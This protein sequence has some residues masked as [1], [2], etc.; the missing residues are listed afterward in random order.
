MN[1]TKVLEKNHPFAA[2]IAA[3]SLVVAVLYLAGFAYRWSYY[4]NFGVQHLVF[5]LNFQSFLITSM[6]LI[7]QPAN[8]L[9]S[10]LSL[11]TSLLFVNFVLYLATYPTRKDHRGPLHKMATAGIRLLG[12]ESPLVVDSIRALVIFYVVYMLSSD[13]GYATFQQHVINSPG[14]PLPAVTAIVGKNGKENGFVLACGERSD[15]QPDLIGNAERVRIIKKA[16]RTC[17]DE[18][19]KWRL[20][21]RDD[22]AIYLFASQAAEHIKGRRPLTIVLPNANDVLLL[23]E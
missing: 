2:L 10:A 22:Q 1:S 16:Y 17:N 23:M 7:R 20:L 15:V 3:S 5:N 14:N 21:Y 12:L 9:I 8:L 6:E 18:T 11:I 4:Y 13:L 19:T